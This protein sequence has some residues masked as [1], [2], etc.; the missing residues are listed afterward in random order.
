M[1]SNHGS[2]I[3]AMWGTPPA[4]ATAQ[5]KELFSR[6][7]EYWTSFVTGGEPVSSDVA[8]EVCILHRDGHTGANRS[9]QEFGEGR[10]LLLD[11]SGIQ[12]ED[13]S[14]EQA[15]RCTFWHGISAELNT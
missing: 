4:K 12:M 10:R 8:W 11:P 6:M 5:D 3:Q 13:I 2:E 7:R 9:R 14:S 15:E 1:G